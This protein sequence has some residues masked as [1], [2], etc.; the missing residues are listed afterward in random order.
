MSETLEQLQPALQAAEV[1]IQYSVVV[2]V[3]NEGGNIAALCRAAQQELPGKFELLICYDFEEDN[4]LPALAAIPADQKPSNVRL[5]RNRL[6]R[7]VRY[8]IEAG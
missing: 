1:E 4:T 7:G 5:V 3:F 2:P 6:G 8:A